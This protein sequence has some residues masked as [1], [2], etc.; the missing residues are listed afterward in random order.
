MMAS[1]PPDPMMASSPPDPMTASSPLNQWWHPLPLTNVV[2]T[3][4]MLEHRYIAPLFYGEEAKM[5]NALDGFSSFSSYLNIFVKPTKLMNI[6]A[7]YS[8]FRRQHFYRSQYGSR[9]SCF[10]R[11]N[12]E[13][14]RGEESS[15]LLP[16][17]TQEVQT[18]RKL[19]ERRRLRRGPG[20][21]MW[22]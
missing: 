2:F 8:L 18:H 10:G 11:G 7:I 17:E 6:T 19:E 9:V 3:G 13:M 21:L 4:D 14:G 12:K 20:H 16:L 1:S 15:I 22:R 5:S